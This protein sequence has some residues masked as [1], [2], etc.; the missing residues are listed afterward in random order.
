MYYSTVQYSTVQYSTVQYA[1]VQYSTYRHV[2]CFGNSVFGKLATKLSVRLS[3]HALCKD[4]R[5]KV[6]HDLL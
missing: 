5:M 2:R 4:R 1:T 3:N 6:V